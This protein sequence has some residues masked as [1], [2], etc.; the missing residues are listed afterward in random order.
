MQQVKQYLYAGM[1]HTTHCDIT[2]LDDLLAEAKRIDALPDT[3]EKWDNFGIDILNAVYIN[4]RNK[5]IPQ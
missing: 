5:E 4:Y 3:P 1:L 2:V